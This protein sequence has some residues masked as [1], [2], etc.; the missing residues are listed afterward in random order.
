MRS[1]SCLSRSFRCCTRHAARTA[2]YA[3]LHEST[4][5]LLDVAPVTTERKEVDPADDAGR[6]YDE[7]EAR[8]NWIIVCLCQSTRHLARSIDGKREL[9]VGI[10]WAKAVAVS[11]R[12]RSRKM[13]AR[14][15]RRMRREVGKKRKVRSC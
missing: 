2:P 3:R 8:P 15:E 5:L 14:V 13:R 9:H 1:A 4:G 10:S 6:E 7:E 11:N 12:G